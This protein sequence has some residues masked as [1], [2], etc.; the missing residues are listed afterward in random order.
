LLL[1]QGQVWDVSSPGKTIE[2]KQVQAALARIGGRRPQSREFLAESGGS[3][4]ASAKRA[5]T[6]LMDL[7]IIYGPDV[8]YTFFDPF[9]KQRVLKEL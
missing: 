4:P 1:S 5:L 7:E 3:L 6:R 2:G 8:G 9:F